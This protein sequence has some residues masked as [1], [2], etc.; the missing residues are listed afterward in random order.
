VITELDA[1]R[2]LKK[3]IQA[4]APAARVYDDWPLEADETWNANALKSPADGNEVHCWMMQRA[5]RTEEAAGTGRDLVQ[6]TF[7]I[8]LFYG[9]RSR[10]QEPASMTI[11]QQEID[12]V[13]AYLAQRRTLEL[14]APGSGVRGHRGLQMYQGDKFPLSGRTVHIA[15]CQLVLELYQHWC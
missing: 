11:F 12:A 5:A 8:W 14:D 9:A 2:Q 6:W 4:A 10:A 13:A 3:L 7:E 15:K 1:R